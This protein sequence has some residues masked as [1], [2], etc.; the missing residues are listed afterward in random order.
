MPY[1]LMPE[2]FLHNPLDI[3][4]PQPSTLDPRQKTLLSDVFSVDVIIDAAS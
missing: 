1:N 4:D 3:I 2:G